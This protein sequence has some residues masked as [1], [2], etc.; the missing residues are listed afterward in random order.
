MPTVAPR[1]LM[2]SFRRHPQDCV[3]PLA[4][5]LRGTVIVLPQ[6]QTQ[7]RYMPWKLTTTRRPYLTPISSTRRREY[8][9]QPQLVALRIKSEPRFTTSLPQSHRQSQYAPVLV[10]L[11]SQRKATKCPKRCPSTIGI[12]AQPQLVDTPCKRLYR[13]TSRSIPQSHRQLHIEFDSCSTSHLPNLMPER[14]E[15]NFLATMHRSNNNARHAAHVKLPRPHIRRDGRSYQY[16]TRACGL[17][18]CHFTM[19]GAI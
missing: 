16:S 17:G 14:S 15:G 6:S 1:L 10:S 5:E 8:C 4:S 11:W 9:S 3:A 12:L 13:Y 18:N 19:K 2:I 7:S